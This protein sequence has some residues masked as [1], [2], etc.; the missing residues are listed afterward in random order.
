MKLLE[1]FIYTVLVFTFSY[2]LLF[3]ALYLFEITE[4]YTAHVIAGIFATILS[5]GV[6]MYLLIKKK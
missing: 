2:V 5:V 1:K 4:K 3:M 6:F